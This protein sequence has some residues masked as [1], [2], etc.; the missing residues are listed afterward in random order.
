MSKLDPTLISIIPMGVGTPMVESLF[1]YLLRLSEINGV[2]LTE[3]LCMLRSFT[4]IP[5]AGSNSVPNAFIRNINGTNEN[6]SGIIEV[7][8]NMTGRRDLKYLSMSR[9]S[10][11]FA[12]G[13][14]HKERWYSPGFKGGYEPLL[15]SIDPVFWGL[16]GLP[17][18][19]H[20]SSCHQT[21][22]LSQLSYKMGKCSKCGA[23]LDRYHT[24]QA[25][26]SDRFSSA[27]LNYNNRDYSLWVATAVGDML[28]YTGDLTSFNFGEAFE[29]HLCH[30][31]IQAPYDAKR[32]LSISHVSVKKW[33]QN[34]VLPRFD[35]FL[36]VC[37]CMRVSPVEFF[38]QDL[39]QVGSPI[40]LRESP[41]QT[42]TAIA[43]SPR[44]PIDA[45]VL[46][47][48]LLQDMESKQYMH[49]SFRE[50]CAK[51]LSRSEAV[52]R[53]YEP[54]LAKRFVAQNKEYQAMHSRTLRAGRIAEVVEAARICIET[55]V[56][57]NHKN[58]RHYLIQPGML[59]SQWARD[60]IKLIKMHGP[61]D[62]PLDSIK[63]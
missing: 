4:K 58:L 60:L 15:Y 7:L 16:D 52:V 53:Q 5:E 8:E 30:F 23:N 3:L 11:L 31:R 35:Q 36:N 45:V 17:L 20:C 34:G 2:T 19:K 43:S 21:A 48:T 9:W 22:L 57:V 42:R 24:A 44:K 1:S 55:D 25:G 33:I 12:P 46:R 63:V 6:I 61:D 32:A 56:D 18:E 13:L 51:Q 38:R 62:L 28:A 50:Y 40:E 14:V 27:F 29:K 47:E 41:K 10:S 37:Y 54:K 49:L 39:L 26:A 59:M